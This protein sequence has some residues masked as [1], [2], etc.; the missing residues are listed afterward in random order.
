MKHRLSKISHE[1]G[2][3]LIEAVVGVAIFVGVS[4]MLYVTY[5]RVF[6][7]VRAA[8]ARTTAV[9]LINEQFEIVRNLPYADVGLV[10]GIPSGKLPP[11][12]VL[13]GG[14]RVYIA[15][16]TV[17]NVDLPFD[18]TVGGT[19][20]DLSP[21]DNKL[22]EIVVSCVTCPNFRPV[23]LVSRVAPKDLE[24]IS[25]NGSLFSRA[26][27]A[28]GLPVDAANVHVFNNTG[29]TTVNINDITTVGG[30]LQIVDAPPGN[31]SYQIQVSKSGY[32]LEQTYSSAGPTTTNPTKPHATVLAQN[33]TQLTF[34]IDRLAT[35]NVSS[36]SPSCAVVPN[37]GMRLTGSK[38]IGSAPDVYK[39][40]KWFSTGA[41]GALT[42]N[43]V[44]WDTYQLIASS[45]SY[46]LAGIMPL[47]P[48]AV[49][50]GATQNIQL[51]VVP[52]DTP[53]ALVAVKD[54]ATGLPITD[55]SVTLTLG[56]VS[57][58]QLTGRGFLS[59]TDW[60]LGGG[61]DMFVDSSRYAVSDGNIDTFSS[62][63]EVKLLDTLGL[64]PPLGE[65]TS[66]TFDTGSASNFYQFLYQPTGQPPA[67]GDSSVRFQIATG[68]GTSS[69]V[70]LGPD[71]TAETYYTA[72]S[73]DVAAVNN[74]HRYLRYKMFVSSASST[75]TPNIADIQFTFTSSCTPPGQ[76]IFQDLPAG[77][78]DVTVVKSGYATYAGTVTVTVGSWQEK[79]VSMSP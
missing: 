7:T 69:W 72:T 18:G 41:S 35:L 5:Q 17:R 24:S 33:V 59:Q 11:V 16:T 3:S 47:S 75:Q 8:E 55:A 48:V 39:Y 54:N 22:V 66:S 67:T 63:G 45:S 43:D 53:S 30:L 70:Y 23:R 56:G 62:P 14:G 25:T 9:Q 12:K 37:V 6:V 44:E 20:N 40:D 32:S 58:T 26:I 36:V 50:P 52:K 46:D 77:V 51:I 49:T 60:S 21:A 27:D 61:Q 1:A 42:L 71:G 79:S 28:G 68:N 4:M 31:E 74:G 64:F 19:P 29:T 73:T 57:V 13:V 65:L 15:T 38:L 10:G 78:W 2:L 34:A 76:V